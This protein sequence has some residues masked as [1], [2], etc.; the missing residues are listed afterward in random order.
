MKKNLPFIGPTTKRE[1]LGLKG[2]RT[3]KHALKAKNRYQIGGGKEAH[4]QTSLLEG[5]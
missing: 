4:H 3:D 5:I 2:H 1:A